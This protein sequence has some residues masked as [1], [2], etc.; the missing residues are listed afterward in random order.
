VATLALTIEDEEFLGLSALAELEKS[1]DAAAMARTL[2]RR[3]LADRLKAADLPGAASAEAIAARTAGSGTARNERLGMARKFVAYILAIATVVVLIGGYG[4]KWQWTGFQA[5]DQLWD[6]LSLLLLPVVV[7]VIPLWIKYR[8]QIDMTRRISHGAALAVWIALVVVG[9]VIPLAWTGFKGQTLWNWLSLLLVPVVV[10][11]TA[12][13]ASMKMSLPALV[14]SLRV[15][16][17]ALIGALAAGV[18]VTV[19]GGY[20]LGWTWTGFQGNTLWDWLSL[21]LLPLIVPTA[22]L[23]GML[24]WV[25]GDEA[26]EAGRSQQATASARVA[27]A[28]AR[29]ESAAATA[30]VSEAPAE[31][32]TDGPAVPAPAGEASDEPADGPTRPA[33]SS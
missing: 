14:R 5:N 33:P 10:V 7:G 29:P 25:A 12:T 9:Y 19:V 16:Y 32:V 27:A 22:L 4:A 30:G 13:I 15:R 1:P 28:D 23:P 21:L 17:Q 6:W 3:A 26:W 20:D 2:L 8:Q 24:R 31:P 11:V 18:V